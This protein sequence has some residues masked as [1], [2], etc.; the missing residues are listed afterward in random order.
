MDI[1][2]G[3]WM[4]SGD[5]SDYGGLDNYMA[6]NQKG[7]GNQNGQVLV[8]SYIV[9]DDGCYQ[10]GYYTAG[11]FFD[12]MSGFPSGAA[13]EHAVL[14]F[15][16]INMNY[17]ATGL[18]A[19]EPASC[20]KNIGRA[21]SDWSGL[22]T[23]NHYSAKIPFKGFVISSVGQYSGQVDVTSTVKSWV[24]NPAGN[25]G[26]FLS[27]ASAPYPLDDGTGKCLSGL[28]NFQLDIYYFAP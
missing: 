26:F 20:I 7:F 24:A 9:D 28:G 19:P 12:I 2:D 10:E 1:S 16:K 13:V 27:A 21:D 8:G 3:E 17:G 11:L 22:S 14:R 4:D 5:C 6:L 23:G 25:H 15:S 18:A